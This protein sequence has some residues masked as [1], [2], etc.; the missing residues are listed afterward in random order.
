[1]AFLAT[2]PVWKRPILEEVE[3]GRGG[4]RGDDP[5]GEDV[6]LVAPR[7]PRQRLLVG[8]R[9]AHGPGPVRGQS[10][11]QEGVYRGAD[12]SISRETSEFHVH[13]QG[14]S[15]NFVAHLHEEG[16]EVAEDEAEVPLLR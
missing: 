9:V 2:Q 6:A 4:R 1:M 13:V 10:E 14:E 8:G 11:Q 7:G 16:V 3:E 15:I 5:E 12:L